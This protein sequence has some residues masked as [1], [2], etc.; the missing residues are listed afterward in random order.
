MIVF[1]LSICLSAFLLFQ[2]QPMIAKL[3]LPWFGGTSAVWSTVMLFFQVL[4]T[5]GYAYGH[6]LIGR[7]EAPRQWKVHTALLLLSIS[8]LVVLGFSWVSP[9]SPPVEWKPVTGE[10]PIGHIFMLLAV[11]VGLP[12]FMLS[13]NSPLIQAW[14]NRIF[15]EQSPYRLYAL[16][17]LGSLLAL[18]SY[19]IIVEPLLSLRWQGW[20]WSGLYIVF[21]LLTAYASF[22]SKPPTTTTRRVPT[23]GG[24]RPTIKS[25]AIWI[26]LSGTASLMLLAITNQMTQ[27][28]AAVPFLWVLPLTL[29]LL[30]FIL[31]FENERWYNRP[32]FSAVLMLATIGFIALIMHP[33]IA[34]MIQIGLYSV[35]AFACFMV[36]HG[37]LYR[38]RPQPAHLTMFY[39]MVSIGGAAG[40]IFVNFIAPVIFTGYW[41]LPYG[42][43]LVWLLLTVV[44]HIRPIKSL[45]ERP[46]FLF[47]LLVGAIATVTLIFSV[48]YPIGISSTVLMSERNFYG[49][50]RVRETEE[51]RNQ[52][53]YILIDGYTQH[54]FQFVSA[55]YRNKPTSYFTEESGI[56][57]AILNHPKRGK[58]MKVGVLGLGIGVLATYGQPGD[59][60]RLYEINPTMIE[61]AEGYGG[62][63]SFLQDSQADMSV[64]LGD[65]RI[66]L[67]RELLLGENHQF[68]L[69]VMDAFSSG[70]VPVHL[71]TKEAIDLYLQHLST[72][73]ILAVNISNRHLDL[74]PVV[75]QLADYFDLELVVIRTP[76]NK[77]LGSNPSLW[78]LLARDSA[79]LDVPAITARARTHDEIGTRNIRMWTDD[80]SNL[81][82]ILK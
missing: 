79:L 62:Y 13:T 73:G 77:E 59:V 6:Y 39:L 19:P 20:I 11:S 30:S 46:R 61:L 8:L 7:I 27:E 24:D 25:I 43:A 1:T 16:S 9:I 34:Y 51:Y 26:T 12:Y 37:E 75:M 23:T 70:S 28:V 80:Y 40:G 64:I 68:D 50:V 48:Y 29:Y 17:N 58:P 53:A 14:F 22:I 74:V 44:A 4:L 42:M 78:A 38:L 60:Y 65:A 2:I 32:F 54:G 47:N 5:G 82:Q 67:E 36:C 55:D 76:E 31:A 56:G 52:T 49:V 18:V 15:P 41:E 71:I 35:L 63:F 3:I 21:G 57:L 45:T 69:L 33:Q 66:A 81:F 10:N 72:E